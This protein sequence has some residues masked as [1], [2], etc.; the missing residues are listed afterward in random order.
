MSQPAEPKPET[1]RPRKTHSLSIR[2]SQQ[3]REMLDDAA[4]RERRA[5][6]E[7][8]ELWL[9]AASKGEET[10]QARIGG[11][12]VAEAITA[13]LDFAK[14]VEAEIGNPRTFLPARDALL[15]GWRGLIDKSLPYV[16]DT[17]EGERYRLA[18]AD[19]EDAAYAALSAALDDPSDE[20]RGWAFAPAPHSGNLL[21]GIYPNPASPGAGS[22]GELLA[23]LSRGASWP[24]A[25][26]LRQRLAALGA[27]P[28]SLQP[29]IETLP[30]LIEAFQKAERE[31]MEPRAAAARRGRA[32]AESMGFIAPARP[33]AA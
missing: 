22:V 14:R 32:L 17:P 20:V 28:Q 9:T 21:A 6:A 11:S 8:A 7:V 5:V 23:N 31:Y 24:I 3:T 2:M 33:G 1:A 4:H 18:R 15:S 27:P 19:L 13:M 12:Q 29:R 16:P 26:L 25:D 10:Y 30:D